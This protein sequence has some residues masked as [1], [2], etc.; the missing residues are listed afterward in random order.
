[1][2]D[3][4]LMTL[5]GNI[6]IAGERQY[7]SLDDVL[8][9]TPF[10]R[11]WDWSGG[12]NEDSLRVWAVQKNGIRVELE[13]R[14]HAGDANN[15]IPDYD[16][17]APTIGEQIAKLEVEALIFRLIE[18][19]Q[20]GDNEWEEYLPITPPDWGKLRRRVEDALRKSTNQE[21]LFAIANRLNVK[22]Y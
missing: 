22:I 20:N 12:R 1:M 16:K 13:T 2:N 15:H 7:T 6:N 11:T 18:K 5:G 17:S 14:I 9:D 3:V 19:D 10:C 4:K 8:R 21:S